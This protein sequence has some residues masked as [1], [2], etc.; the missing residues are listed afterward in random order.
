M[1]AAVIFPSRSTYIS[2]IYDF[3][4]IFGNIIEFQNQDNSLNSISRM[5][6]TQKVFINSGGGAHSK[7]K[8]TTLSDTC[9]STMDSATHSMTVIFAS[10]PLSL[11]CPCVI[12]LPCGSAMSPNCCRRKSMSKFKTMLWKQQ[13]KCHC[14]QVQISLLFFLCQSLALSRDANN[15]SVI[16]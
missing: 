3:L 2:C 10:F 15:E 1:T 16:H 11:F 14:L 8:K 12:L 5:N 13:Q 9:I 6:T 4:Y 7:V